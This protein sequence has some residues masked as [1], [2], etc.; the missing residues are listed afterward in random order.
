MLAKSSILVLA[1]F[2]WNLSV[3]R[4]AHA[5]I[6]AGTGSLIVQSLIGGIAAIMMVGK[7]MFARL[8]G[9]LNRKA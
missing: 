3:A 6:D 8:F 5:Y 4:D 9:R 1:I 2:V 7:L